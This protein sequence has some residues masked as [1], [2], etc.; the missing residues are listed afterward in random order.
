MLCSIAFP[1]LQSVNLHFRGA[2]TECCPDITVGSP[3]WKTPWVFSVL[4]TC[5]YTLRPRWGCMKPGFACGIFQTNLSSVEEYIGRCPHFFVIFFFNPP[6]TSVNYE[7][8]VVPATQKK[9][10]QVL[11]YCDCWERGREDWSQIRRQQKSV[12][13]YHFYSLS[14]SWTLLVQRRGIIL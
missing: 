12:S 11:W 9:V 7:N 10:R 4:C 1:V 6:H 13:I 5:I 14:T 3:V 8:Q 2:C